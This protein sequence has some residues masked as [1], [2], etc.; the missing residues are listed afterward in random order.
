M[1]RTGA[2]LLLGVSL[3]AVTIAWWLPDR[4]W[5]N[6]S[7]HAALEAT[8]AT[9]LIV[10]A[11]L[12]IFFAKADDAV[13]LPVAIPMGLLGMGILTAF[14]AALEA[15]SRIW[16]DSLASAVGG[17]L[18]A[19]IY[20]RFGKADVARHTGR[21]V[22][23]AV[24]VTALGGLALL[25]PERAVLAGMLKRLGGILLLLAAIRF[26][27]LRGMTEDRDYRL[28]AVFCTLC[29]L[30]DMLFATDGNWDLRWWWWH[31]LRWI[32]ALGVTYY[33]FRRLVESMLEQQRVKEHFRQIFERMSSG[34]VVYAAVDDGADFVFDDI[35]PAVERNEQLP[36]VDIIG[37]RLTQRFP[38]VRE[39]GFLDLLQRV[40][41]S[42]IPED[43]PLKLYQDQR[44]AGWR[45]NYV[46]RLSSGK[47]IAIYDDVTAQKQ[48]EEAIRMT[49]DRLLLATQAA[50]IG[51]WSWEFATNA[52]IWD[53]RM[54]EIYDLPDEAEN[55]LLYSSW[56]MRCHP[57]DRQ[58]ADDAVMAARRGECDFNIMFRI[59]LSDG[60]IRFVQAVARRETDHAGQPIR[61]VGINRDISAQHETEAILRQAKETADAANRAKSDFL[62]NMSH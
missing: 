44:I 31:V 54:Y 19:T 40:W 10:V 53:Q 26:S 60:R 4:S 22:L 59:V 48:A 32:A 1:P 16:A 30:S 21:L 13:R 14:H 3:L 12:I 35:N 57:D 39:F 62:A 33:L 43:M 46:Y 45:E 52:L 50:E 47:V 27:V 61:L 20:L 58:V 38:G 23:V 11:T 29:G 17:L 2:W 25:W 36:R 9:L 18:F 5:Q 56:L 51:I 42:G 8:A 15:D 6:L 49:R 34:V 41:T 28:F 7:A 37:Q 24:L 55:P